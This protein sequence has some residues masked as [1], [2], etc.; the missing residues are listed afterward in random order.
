MAIGLLGIGSGLGFYAGPRFAG[1]RA[2]SAHWNWHGITSW[3]R[4]CVE[5][6]LAGML[7]GILFLF[8]ARE[9]RPRRNDAATERTIHPPLGKELRWRVTSI[10]LV[11]SCRDF[12]GVACLSLS[13]IYL[14]RAL[15]TDLRET[16]LI[17]GTMMLTGVIANPLAVWLSPGRRRLPALTVVLIAAGISIA[18]VPLF[19]TRGSALGMLCVFQSLQLGSYAMSDAGILE[20]V[21]A[22]TRGRVVGL[23][24]SIAGTFAGLSPWAM[25]FWTDKMHQSATQRLPYLVPFGTLGAM[26]IFSALSTP[27]IARLGKPD[28]CAINP[29]SEIMPRTMEVV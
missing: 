3:Q 24:L 12:A 18:L 6:G 28:E 17:L 19:P 25:G 8:L 13:S 21:P 7:F 15:G 4:P 23:F 9:A 20:R 26:M 22:N 1:W 16:G 2:E 10:A 5:A 11:L 29:L 14:Q 27:I